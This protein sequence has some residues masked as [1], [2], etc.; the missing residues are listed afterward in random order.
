ME[1]LEESQKKLPWFAWRMLHDSWGFAFIMN[2][3]L[4]I[5]FNE[6]D[7]I[8]S[9]GDET[10]IDVKVE[11]IDQAR[12]LAKDLG[13]KYYYFKS[14]RRKISVNAKDISI[15]MELWDS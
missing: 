3:N 6:I 4:V 13:Y 7:K 8:T 11:D 9:M 15:A 10:W 12:E 5:A 14:E 2:N 1:S